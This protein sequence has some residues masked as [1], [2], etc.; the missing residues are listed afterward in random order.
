MGAVE[1][2]LSVYIAILICSMST[3]SALQTLWN[4]RDR[5]GYLQK[6]SFIRE[7]QVVK[8]SG[9]SIDYSMRRR[10]LIVL[11]CGRERGGLHLLSGRAFLPRCLQGSTRLSGTGENRVGGSRKDLSSGSQMQYLNVTI[12]T[13]H[14]RT[15]E[16]RGLVP[17]QE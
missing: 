9:V 13:Y 12:L 2:I 10:R 7:E 5:S 15:E 8:T 1:E 14:F 4:T 17:V 3:L 11:S 6:P 16:Q